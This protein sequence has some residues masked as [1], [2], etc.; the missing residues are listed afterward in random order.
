MV[1]YV[2]C[3]VPLQ[4]YFNRI[5]NAGCEGRRQGQGKKEEEDEYS[6][7]DGEAFLFLLGE[8]AAGGGTR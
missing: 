3:M 5:F 4:D 8:K 1:H 7:E 6:S 2:P